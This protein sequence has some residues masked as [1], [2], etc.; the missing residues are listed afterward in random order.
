LADDLIAICEPLLV[1][2]FYAGLLLAADAL[3]RLYSA[4]IDID[5]LPNEAPEDASRAR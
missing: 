2:A 1:T 4:R 3:L 5:L